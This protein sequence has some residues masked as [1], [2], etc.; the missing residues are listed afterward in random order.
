[1]WKN[2]R[3]NVGEPFSENIDEGSH[4]ACLIKANVHLA[5]DIQDQP[6]DRGVRWRQPQQLCGSD[7][8]HHQRP[9]PAPTLGTVRV[10]DHSAGK[11]HARR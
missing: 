6:A 1:M 4:S 8:H 10:L 5:A 11:H 2:L 7:G 9:Q 3:V